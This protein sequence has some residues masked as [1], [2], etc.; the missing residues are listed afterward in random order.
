MKELLRWEA[1]CN[2]LV[3]GGPCRLTAEEKR[4]KASS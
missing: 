2:T 4:E 3:F 1:V